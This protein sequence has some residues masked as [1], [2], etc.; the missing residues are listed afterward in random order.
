M[1]NPH[2]PLTTHSP[3]L[4]S[5]RWMVVD[6]PCYP[7]AYKVIRVGHPFAN[8]GTHNFFSKLTDAQKEAAR[9]NE[10]ANS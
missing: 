7:C 4:A 6:T 10:R 5:G 9:R 2:V 1:T 3:I 8:N